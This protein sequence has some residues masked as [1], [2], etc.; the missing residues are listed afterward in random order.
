MLRL[1]A[2]F[3]GEC[4]RGFAALA[5]P[6]ARRAVADAMNADDSPAFFRAPRTA[7]ATRAGE[8]SPFCCQH[9]KHDAQ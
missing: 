3:H 7:T 2:P 8:A 4:P 1:S 9:G 6:C 5:L